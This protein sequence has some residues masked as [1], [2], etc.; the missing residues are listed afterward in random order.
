MDLTIN[1]PKRRGTVYLLPFFFFFLA[2]SR[3][4]D[5]EL[6]RVEFEK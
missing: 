1:A 6:K 2:V 4:A 3:S 5:F